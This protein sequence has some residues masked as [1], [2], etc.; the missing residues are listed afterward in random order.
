[1]ANVHFVAY[2]AV[3]AALFQQLDHDKAAGSPHRLCHLAYRQGAKHAVERRWQLPGFTPAHFATFQRGF[4]GRAGNGQLGEVGTLLQLLV[5]LTSLTLGRLNI[6][7][8][9][10]FGDRY[11]DVSQAEFFRQLHLAHV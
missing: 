5:Q 1:M 8:R 11:Q 10:S 7:R 9:C 4:A 6:F 3:T 2:L